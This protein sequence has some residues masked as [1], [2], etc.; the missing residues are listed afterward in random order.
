MQIDRQ[1]LLFFI[2]MFIFLSLPNGAD[3]PHSTKDKDTLVTY[4]DS[5]KHS[6]QELIGSKYHTGYGNLTGLKLSYVDSLENKNIL[7]WPFHKYNEK[8]PWVEDEKYSLLPNEISEKVKKF[9]GVEPISEQDVTDRAYLLNI[10]GKVYGEYEINKPKKTLS[11]I[12]LP[13]PTYLQEYFDSYTQDQKQEQRDRYEQD[14]DNN[15]P[16]DD[17]AE[18]PGLVGNITEP[19]GKLSLGIKSYD[20]N[21]HNLKLSKF[22]YNSSTDSLNDTVVVDV[23]LNLVDYDEINHNELITKGIYFQNTGSLISSTSSAKFAGY[24]ALPHFSMNEG[25]F[26][27]S[28]LLMSQLLNSTDIDNEISLEEMNTDITRSYQQCEYITFFQFD[29]TEFLKRQLQEIDEELMNPT[30]RP[31]PK[32]IP[33]IKIKEALLY[34]P[35][36]GLMVDLKKDST[37][38][39]NKTEVTDN[40]FKRMLSALLVLVLLQLYLFIRQIKETRTPGQLSNISTTTLY[41]LAFQDSL[42]ALFFLLVSTLTESLYLL[43]S[44]VAVI[45]FI[46]CGVFEM[47]FIVSVMVTQ[48]NERGTTWW[49]VLRGSV[50]SYDPD[51]NNDSNADGPT[52]NNSGADETIPTPAVEPQPIINDEARYS[53]GLFASG[54][55]LTIIATFLILNVVTWRIKYRQIFEYIGLLVISS[56]WL[57]QFLRNTLKNRRRSFTWEFV[58]GTSVLRLLPLCYLCLAS[59]NPLRHHYDPTLV[60]VVTVWYC[61]Q[62]GLLYLQQNLGARF[63]LNEKWLPKAYDYHPFLNVSDLENGF[64]SDILSNIRAQNED[65]AKSGVVTCKVDCTIC[66]NDIELPIGVNAEAKKPKSAV[67]N[68]LQYMI[69]PCHHIFHTECLEDWMKY[70]LQCPV[71]RNALPPI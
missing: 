46:M 66:M 64:A 28:K 9:W 39:G 36:C 7:H 25:N 50:R 11:E 29:K 8:N 20:Y 24:H 41:I 22:I 59:G 70:K 1:T 14:P 16:P 18:S 3:Q 63:W 23:K 55:S 60:V 6:Q 68:G 37:L 13:L 48:A 69:T 44:C 43:F 10:S 26:N 62:I 71:C 4:Q 30:G 61:F 33:Q 52:G 21:F 12:H 31:I 34:S 2:I 32:A 53:N 5:L 35:D 27:K 47:R 17:E 67:L 15:P 58:V 45:E 65:P 49:E 42:I 19:T 51:D 54:F 56:Y 38:Q 40:L 57:P